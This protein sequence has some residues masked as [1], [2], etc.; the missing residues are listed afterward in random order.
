MKCAAHPK[1]QVKRKPVSN[2]KTCK[3]IWKE[4]QI[5]EKSNEKH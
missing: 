3:H 5:K 4:K 2:C 1:Y